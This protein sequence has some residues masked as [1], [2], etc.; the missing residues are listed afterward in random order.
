M[1][2]D[3]M[4]DDERIGEHGNIEWDAA[5]AGQAPA[6]L[7]AAIVAGCGIG[8]S[9]PWA[10]PVHLYLAA[11]RGGRRLAQ[12]WVET[13]E[14]VV[15]AAAALAH[16]VRGRVDAVDVCALARWRTLTW[17]AYKRLGNQRRGVIAVRF[18]APG[19]VRRFAPLEAIASNRRFSRLFEVYLRETGLDEPGFARA[20]GR[21][22]V[23]DAAQGQVLLERTPRL[24]AFRRGAPLVRPE[25]LDAAAIVR[26]RDL[27]ADWLRRALHDDGRMTY[28]YWPSVGR[29]TSG[30]NMIRQFMASLALVRIG[31]A[32]GDAAWFELARRNLDYNF[33]KFYVE[34]DGL[35][36]IRANGKAKLGA[37]ALAALAIREHPDAARWAEIEAGLFAGIEHL[38]HENGSFTTF[39]EPVGRNDNQNFY[40]G[41]ALLYLAHRAGGALDARL[42]GRVDTGLAWYRRWHLENRNP[43]FVPWHSMAAAS[44]FRISRAAWLRDWVFEMND[45]L[46]SMQQW[47]S[48]PMPELKGRFYDP[49]R[50]HYGPPHASSTGVYLEGLHEAWAL[51]HEAGDTAREQAYRRAIWRG[52]R[53]VVQLQFK[54]ELDMFYITRRERALGGIRTTTYDNRIRVDNVQHNLLALLGICAAPEL[55]ERPLF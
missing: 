18:E 52:L 38:W 13:G 26:T 5:L 30:N 16:E 33:A 8:E 32:T 27:A 29:E 1:A 22:A 42:A 17:D 36:R 39:L 43:A 11:R 25:D 3:L 51:A 4:A 34:L 28:E 6:A 53:S 12:R 20:G 55:L 48:A 23:A 44:L 46:L 31:H 14:D 45:W 19:L 54:D 41:E 9:P 35:G 10:A 47:D 2:E 24:V 50:A 7:V 21:I 49:E 37:A 15:V 40:P